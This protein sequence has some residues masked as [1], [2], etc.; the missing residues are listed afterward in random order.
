VKPYHWWADPKDQLSWHFDGYSFAAEGI[1]VV[2]V[3]PAIETKAG[4]SYVFKGPILNCR[5]TDDTIDRL[6]EVSPFAMP[7]VAAYGSVGMLV[8][9]VAARKTATPGP[10]D[11]VGVSRYVHGWR[12]HG[13]RIGRLMVDGQTAVIVWE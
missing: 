1:P 6:P 3:R 11:G 5:I 13:A 7:A 4:L 2:D 8:E 10:L 12:E 9:T